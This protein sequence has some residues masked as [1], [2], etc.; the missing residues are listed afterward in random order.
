MGIRLVFRCD[1]CHA[2][3]DRETLEGQLHDRCRAPY[4]AV[5]PGGWLI[6]TAGGALG[7]RRYAC[8]EHRDAP[9]EHVRVHGA[10]DRAAWQTAP[11]PA[12]WPDACPHS[13][14][15][16]SLSSRAV[17]PAIARR[18]PSVGCAVAATMPGARRRPQEELG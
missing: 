13:T 5:Q 10:I 16:S 14:T 11:Y 6:W 7:R 8:P 12:L 18:P 2:R 17:V 3:Q 4:L 9:V 15:P 1:H